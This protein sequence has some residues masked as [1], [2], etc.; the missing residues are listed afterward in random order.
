MR[1]LRT[2]RF[3]AVPVVAV[4]TVLIIDAVWL[5]TVD[6]SPAN[7]TRLVGQILLAEAAWLMMWA[8]LLGLFTAMRVGPRGSE[9]AGGSPWKRVLLG[10]VRL[11]RPL[12]AQI[13]LMTATSAMGVFA[14]GTTM[15]VRTVVWSHAILWAAALTLSMLGAA[16]AS[17]Y[18]EPLDAGAA[19]VGLAVLGT[20]ALFAGG[21]A[22]DA[23][24]EALLQAA[25]AVNPIVATAASADIDLWRT[26]VLYQVSPFAH[27]HVEFPDI[28]TTLV[29]YLLIAG[30]LWLLA[31]RLVM[32]KIDNPS[33]ER[34]AS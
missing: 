22:L 3:A 7:R 31:A 30:A 24:P 27:R 6:L 5:R 33:L 13:T 17:I 32:H 29:A 2:L 8:P 4:G 18:R 23:I 11:G 10:A 12:V 14:A 19:A 15:E 16:C 25:L 21:P 34:I 1:V 20:I 9:S 26:H 28:G